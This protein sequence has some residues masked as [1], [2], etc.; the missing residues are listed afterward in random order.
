MSVNDYNPNNRNSYS[1]NGSYRGEY[2]GE[3][4]GIGTANQDPDEIDLKRLFY[5][6]WHNKWMIIASVVLFS[7]LAGIYAYSVTPIYRSEGSMLIK[8]SGN[9]LSMGGDEGLA[10]MLSSSYGIGMGSTIANELQILRSRSLSQEMADS[11]MEQRIMSNGR[12]F[13][14]LFK[15]Y[16][17][18]SV[19]EV[20]DTVAIRLRENFSF[21]QVDRE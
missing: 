19:M 8:D 13:P 4:G 9:K 16:P 7:V 18:D 14:V 17:D 10:S 1:G 21:S 5:T 11:L 15:S 2:N 12:Q 3:Q 6:L 20:Q